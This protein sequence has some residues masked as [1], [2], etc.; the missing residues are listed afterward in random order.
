MRLREYCLVCCKGHCISRERK[1]VNACALENIAS[2]VSCF[3]WSEVEETS[4]FSVSRRIRP[5]APRRLH[6]AY[7]FSQTRKCSEKGK[8]LVHLYGRSM[9][10]AHLSFFD[11]L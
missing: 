2:C 10:F 8:W 1:G 7:L 3:M 4:S 6:N 9:C 5:R 11:F